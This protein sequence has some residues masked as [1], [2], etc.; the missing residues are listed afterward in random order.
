MPAVMA[1]GSRTP[2]PY[3]TSRPTPVATRSGPG[4]SLDFP[5]R[6]SRET[7]CASTCTSESRSFTTPTAGWPLLN[8]PAS[9][10]HVFRSSRPCGRLSQ[11]TQST[12]QIGHRPGHLARPP[13]SRAALVVSPMFR[14]C[15]AEMGPHARCH[16]ICM[17]PRARRSRFQNRRGPRLAVKSE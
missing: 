6:Y 7:P 9:R 10:R 2:G 14:H 4:G 8:P 13:A 3:P 5:W 12:P 17:T 15:G 1:T 16:R 11:C